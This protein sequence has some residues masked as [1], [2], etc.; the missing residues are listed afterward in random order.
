MIIN[1][2]SLPYD[3]ASLP[4]VLKKYDAAAKISQDKAILKSGTHW[5]E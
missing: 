3:H 4:N 5:L 2:T 1:S